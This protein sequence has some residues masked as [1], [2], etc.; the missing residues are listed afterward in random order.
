MSEEYTKC[1]LCGEIVDHVTR[2]QKQLHGGFN[3]Y[4]VCDEC[5]EEHKRSLEM[6]RN[7]YA[8]Q[9]NAYYKKSTDE[10]KLT[11]NNLHKIIDD[12][13]ERGDRQVHISITKY[14][15]S[16]YVSPAGENDGMKWIEQHKDIAAYRCSDCGGFSNS[17]DTYCKHCGAQRT[18]IRRILDSETQVPEITL[19]KKEKGNE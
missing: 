2:I 14:G 7:N 15:T 19:Y 11:N 6:T 16:V 8:S 5:Y 17:A 18:G 4:S 12:A 3:F 9:V 10:F 13:M 1:D